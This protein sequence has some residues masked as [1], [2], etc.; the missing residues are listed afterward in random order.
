MTDTKKVTIVPL[1]NLIAGSV[2]DKRSIQ[3]PF[4]RVVTAVNEI[5]PDF[6]A[7]L[8][9]GKGYTLLIDPVTLATAKAMQEQFQQP[10]AQPQYLRQP[11]LGGYAVLNPYGLVGSF[12]IIPNGHDRVLILSGQHLTSDLA[13]AQSLHPQ[14]LS[15]MQFGA[16]LDDILGDNPAVN[17]GFVTE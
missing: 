1:A 7:I 2:F 16:V 12:G 9:E 14:Q 8:R 13:M 6:G 17:R 4:E 15:A 5:D 10:Q 3:V 11:H